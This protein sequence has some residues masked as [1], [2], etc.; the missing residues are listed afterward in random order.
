MLVYPMIT[1]LL[2]VVLV[3]IYQRLAPR[4]ALAG[5][6]AAMPARVGSRRIIGPDDDEEFLRFLAE[7]IRRSR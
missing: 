6:I 4:H 7:R 5:L 3:V 1:A 2:V